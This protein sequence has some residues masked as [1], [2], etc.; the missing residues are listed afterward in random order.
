[1]MFDL[2]TYSLKISTY[3]SQVSNKPVVC[4]MHSLYRVWFIQFSAI[5]LSRYLLIFLLFGANMAA[6]V[7]DAN[8]V[9]ACLKIA[10]SIFH[11]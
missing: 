11:S 10:H 3:D 4:Y 5:M 2:K 6:A 9:L 1:M 7:A 8:V